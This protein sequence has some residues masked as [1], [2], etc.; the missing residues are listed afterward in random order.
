M[1][2]NI[3]GDKDPTDQTNW[4]V[5][6]ATGSASEVLRG[7]YPFTRVTP[8][9][10]EQADYKG[11]FA[12]RLLA[13]ADP[14]QEPKPAAVTDF[15]REFDQREYETHICE[16][17]KSL[18]NGNHV[19]LDKHVFCS[20]LAAIFGYQFG[21]LAKDGD[22]VRGIS[23]RDPNLGIASNWVPAE[24]SSTYTPPIGLVDGVT[25]GAD[26]LDKRFH[27]WKYFKFW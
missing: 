8:W 4:Y 23:Y 7:R 13:F 3:A 25:M 5:L 22:I 6:E 24:F 14:S 20:E 2:A 15:V 11:G 18:K 16:L 19:E 1:L 27:W 21:I 17:L 26:I 12:H 9:I 10:Q